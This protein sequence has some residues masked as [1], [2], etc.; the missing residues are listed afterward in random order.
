MT[1]E[2]KKIIGEE[3]QVL[4]KESME[5]IN[6][7]DWE[8][9]SK[10]IGSKYLFTEEEQNQ[11]DA[12]IVLVMLGITEQ[13]FLPSR[14]E[15]NIITT[16]DNAEKITEEIVEKILKPIVNTLSEK[17]KSTLKSRVVHWQQNLD[18]ILSGGDYTAFIRDPII[19]TEEK[20]DA[21]NNPLSNSKLDDLKSSFTI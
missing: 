19:K 15:N 9:V 6:S 5:A 8:K 17:I 3:L 2:L 21:P 20:N 14:I 12:E 16:H 13:E 10:E 4:P 7:F 11:L 1:E 18:F